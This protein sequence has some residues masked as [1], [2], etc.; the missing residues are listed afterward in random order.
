ME[1]WSFT[2]PSMFLGSLLLP[3]VLLLSF[4]CV[5]SRKSPYY[6]QINELFCTSLWLLWCFEILV[7]SHYAVSQLAVQVLVF[8]L[9]ALHPSLFD[10]AVGN[11]CVLMVE[12]LQGN[13]KSR[14]AILLFISQLLAIPFTIATVYYLWSVLGTFSTSHGVMYRSGRG[15][16]L[17][18]S[19]PMGVAC[20]ALITFVAFVPVRFMDPGVPRDFVCAV[21]FT[22]VGNILGPFTGAFFNP[23]PITAFSFFFYNQ[24]WAELATVYWLGSTVG[25]CL[26]Y[27][28]LFRKDDSGK[29]TTKIS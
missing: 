19:L 20:E 4:R 15:T 25:G 14:S 11:P 8:P 3:Y 29:K 22:I 23:L 12:W 27:V 5:I 13:I 7:I 17:L 24:T 21:Y 2:V 26:A 10:G 9:I 6:A 16:F 28:V 1:A 18:S